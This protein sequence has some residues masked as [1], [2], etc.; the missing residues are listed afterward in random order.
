MNKNDRTKRRAR[1]NL[2]RRTKRD[3]KRN[4]IKY[5]ENL[6]SAIERQVRKENRTNA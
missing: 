6:H 4:Q 5:L 2:T 3:Q 1:K